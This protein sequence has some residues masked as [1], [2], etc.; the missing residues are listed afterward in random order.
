LAALGIVFGDIGTSPLYTLKTILSMTHAAPAN[1]T[2]VL[3]VLS[4]IIWTL[5]IIT[6]VKYVAFAMSIAN[7][8]EGGI[9]A[10]MSL[11]GTKKRQPT[12]IV[13]MGLFGAALIYG[14][15]AITPAISVLCALE[16]LTIATPVVQPYVLPAAVAILIAVF[17]IQPQ[18]TARIGK[19]FGPIMCL[20]F[21]AEE[22]SARR[23]QSFD[24]VLP[25]DV[26]AAFTGRQRRGI[27]GRFEFPDRNILWLTGAIVFGAMMVA[28]AIGLRGQH[29]TQPTAAMPE[30]TSSA[31]PAQNASPLPTPA[32]AAVGRPAL[33]TAATASQATLVKLPPPRA[34]L[35]R[36]PQ[37][38]V[39]EERPVMMPYGLEVEARLKGRLPS[40]DGLPM[41]GNS[42]GDAWVVGHSAWVWVAAPGTGS[43]NWIDP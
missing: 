41:S 27:L 9:L 13:A 12:I 22:N 39:G 4:L 2:V 16:G 24:T 33:D 20:W 37:W 26:R 11:L 8:G 17:A 7:D 3:G 29:Q 28:L 21:L 36:L 35:V 25:D 38:H 15:G 42:I 30:P 43:A 40:T 6:S 31:R 10:L 19:A 18:G 23:I 5:I 34:V 1:V 32:L 14:D